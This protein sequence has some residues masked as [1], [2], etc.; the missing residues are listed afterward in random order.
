MLT[1]LPLRSP[2]WV[3]WAHSA[4]PSPGDVPL[5]SPPPSESSASTAGED[6]S[7]ADENG[8]DCHS[9]TRVA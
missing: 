9:A 5:A 7:P 2:N 6:E 3:S 1:F 8:S 4:L